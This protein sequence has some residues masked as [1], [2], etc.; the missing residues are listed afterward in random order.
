MARLLVATNNPALHTA[1]QKVALEAHT[2]FTSTRVALRL[3]DYDIVK[4][5]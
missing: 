3:V 1:T 4:C 2:H 5:A